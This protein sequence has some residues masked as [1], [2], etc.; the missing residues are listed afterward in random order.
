M[1]N[2]RRNNS[3]RRGQAMVECALILVTFL[4]LLI[5][6]VDFGQVMYFHQGLAMRA[7]IGAQWAAVNAF[8]A[9][10]ITN[11][12]VYGVATPT[13]ANSPVISGLSASN[14]TA[15]LSNA[16]TTNSIVE[17]RI[18]NYQFRFFSPWIASAHT[19]RPIVARMPHE[20][21]LP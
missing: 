19:N 5:G 10:K 20:A 21:T 2:M 4:A 8:D 3:S 7:R 18:E 14:V 16:N 17:V 15:T 1:S 9:T 13:S 6:T 12:V 11:M